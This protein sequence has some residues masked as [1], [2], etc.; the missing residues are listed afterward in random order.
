MHCA[1]IAVTDKPCETEN[2]DL[3]MVSV[4]TSA[5]VLLFITMGILIWIMIKVASCCFLCVGVS[6]NVFIRLVY[7]DSRF[8]CG[9]FPC[10][11]YAVS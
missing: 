4:V 2:S 6:V 11:C 7:Y 1:A 3:F 9:L 10:S 8:S 5:A